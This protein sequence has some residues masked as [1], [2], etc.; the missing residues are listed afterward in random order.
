MFEKF[1]KLRGMNFRKK[2]LVYIISVMVIVILVL[3]GVT[4]MLA[5][6]GIM[7]EEYKSMDQIVKKTTTEIDMWITDRERDVSLFA[8]NN[9]FKDACQGNNLKE[10]EA[11]LIE[12]HKKSPIYENMFLADPTGKILLDSIGGKSVGLDVSKLDGVKINIEKA[13]RGEIWVDDARKSPAT[14]R[15]TCLVTA[16]ITSQGRLIGIMGTPVEV[17]NFSDTFVSQSKIGDTGYL[18][19]VDASGIVLA[20]PRKEN[21]LK[22]NIAKDFDWGKK[23]IGEKN[24]RIEYSYNDTEKVASFGSAA[25][26]GWIVAATI[27]KSELLSSVG[28]IKFISFLLGVAAIILVSVVLWLVTGNVFR[29][30][31]RVSNELNDAS[32]QIASASTQVASASQ[33]LAQGASEQASSI[34]MTSSSM[35]VFS[36]I[37]RQ[38]ADNTGHANKLMEEAK[39]VVGHADNSMKMLT[40]SMQEITGA[41]EET[42]KIVKT[43]DEIAFQTNL[44]ALN[45]AVEAARAGEAGAGFAVVA[46]EVRNLAMRAAE[47]AKNTSVL[48]DGTVRKI[49]DG[50]E[51][52]RKTNEDFM[53]VAKSSNKV[54]DLIGEIS[55]ASVEQEQGIG[56]ISNAVLEMEKVVQQNAANA[57]ESASASE[58]MNA[59]ANQMKMV[60]GELVSLV[61]GGS[62]NQKRIGIDHDDKRPFLPYNPDTER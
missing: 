10:A 58:E 35:E 54:A 21:I 50:S 5:S 29:V 26:K 38:N 20:D 34:Q 16:P 2:L 13:Q 52:G 37:A 18:F 23:M 27:N 51:L 17:N 24:G 9:V 3:G 39:Q 31:K 55:A 28:K 8:M 25:K 42:S 56:Q 46:E 19:M 43:I 4:Y 6:R 62:G 7:N 22:I 36:S 48:I 33:S 32:A 11:S 45:A 1:L 57:E 30:I 61:E 14:G 60:V 44:L 12:Y 53:E 47:A 59:Q 40:E 41:S 49:K 15:P